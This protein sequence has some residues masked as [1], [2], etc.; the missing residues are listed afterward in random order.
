MNCGSTK[1]EGSKCWHCGASIGSNGVQASEEPVFEVMP[2]GL[3]R[4]IEHHGVLGTEGRIYFIQAG[5]GGPI[6]IGYSLDPDHRLLQL[7]TGN[8]HQL[9]ILLVIEG[10]KD[11]EAILHQRFAYLRT[12]G[13]WFEPGKELVKYI[14]DFG[15]GNGVVLVPGGG[16][17]QFENQHW[18]ARRWW[19][20][21]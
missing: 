15:F 5:L 18:V 3:Q 7:Q 20:S 12:E 1:T 2:K 11:H 19:T 16:S 6:K 17:I 10:D 4:E 13:E 8:S 21:V 9:R 14:R